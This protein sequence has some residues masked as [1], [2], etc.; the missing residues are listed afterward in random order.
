MKNKGYLNTSILVL[1]WAGLLLCL[2]NS[3]LAQSAHQHLLSADKN[4]KSQD[5]TKAEEAYRKALEKEPSSEGRYNLGNAIYN[6]ERYDEAVRRYEQVVSTEKDPGIKANAYHNMG[7]AYYQQQ[8]LEESIEAYKNALRLNPAD[9]ETKYN[10]AQAQRQLMLQKEQQ[11]K[12]QQ[13][14]E[15]N[16]DQEQEQ[17]DQQQNEGDPNED[18]QQQD[19][20]QQAQ[21][22]QEGEN[23]QGE[24]QEQEE[25]QQNGNK[26]PHNTPLSEEE[27]R[28]LLQIVEDEEMKVMEKLKKGE[29]SDQKGKDW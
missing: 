13:E 26:Q 12:E 19:N 25:E 4:Y 29:P 14:K 11:K 23:E 10:L 24:E 17:Q 3:G 8:K 27:A 9:L 20:Q 16:E 5:Y 2:A 6:Q 18:Q 1:L 15:Q 7:N 22:G 28:R 21:P